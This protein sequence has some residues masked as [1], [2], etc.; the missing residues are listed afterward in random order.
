V[1][2]WPLYFDNGGLL[3]LKLDFL[4]RKGYRV[5]DPLERYVEGLAEQNLFNYHPKEDVKKERIIPMKI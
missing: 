4:Y 5:L 2:V 3:S 1:G